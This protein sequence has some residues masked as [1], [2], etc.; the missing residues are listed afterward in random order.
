MRYAM[1]LNA[2]TSLFQPT[3]LV[4][5]WFAMYKDHIFGTLISTCFPE[6]NVQPCCLH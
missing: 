2:T 4:R 3:R 1:N 5:R 6:V